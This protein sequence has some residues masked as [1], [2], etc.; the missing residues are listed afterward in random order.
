MPIDQHQLVRQVLILVPAKHELH[1]L[2]LLDHDHAEHLLLQ[3]RP[4][5]RVL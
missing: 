3:F 4:I 1:D 5:E 2:F